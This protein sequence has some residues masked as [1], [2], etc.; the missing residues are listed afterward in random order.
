MI[1]LS[2]LRGR[3]ENAV[4][5]TSIHSSRNNRWAS[6][7]ALSPSDTPL[8]SG[9]SAGVNSG[10]MHRSPRRSP[11]PLELHTGS[12]IHPRL[13]SLAPLRRPQNARHAVPGPGYPA[14][15][16]TSWL[17]SFVALVLR[18]V[19]AGVP[20]LSAV[21]AFPPVPRSYSGCGTP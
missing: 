2:P 21:V 15:T 4:Q 12:S 20:N 9:P 10:V 11:K 7:I 16:W 6:V 19:C 17:A 18:T 8:Y 14:S 13:L 5:L 3:N 1:R